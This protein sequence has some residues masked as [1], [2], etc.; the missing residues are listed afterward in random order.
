LSRRQLALALERACST[1]P[2]RPNPCPQMFIAGSGG[3]LRLRAG[4]G[5]EI[6]KKYRAF[7]QDT[8]A[9]QAYARAQRRRFEAQALMRLPVTQP[10]ILL[11]ANHLHLIYLIERYAERSGCRVISANTVDAALDLLLRDRPAML[12]L[13]LISGSH[14]DWST[15]RRLKENPAT[16]DTPITIISALADEAGA[17]DAGAA[18]WLWQP[19]MYADFLAA[20]VATGVLPHTSAP[21]HSLAHDDTGN[22]G[23]R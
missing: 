10:T 4:P 18:Y 2:P 19:V 1:T 14:A 16:G 17:R 5:A 3:L 9:R 23:P 22:H 11:L 12:L 15:L 6:N 20:L 8:G 7:Y 13:H 21:R